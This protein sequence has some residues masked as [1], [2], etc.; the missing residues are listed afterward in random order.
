M[1]NLSWLFLLCGLSCIASGQT[2]PP[3]GDKPEAYCNPV[4]YDTH[5]PTT[6]TCSGLSEEQV[7]DIEKLLR[8]ITT[9]DR[10]NRDVILKRID[11]DAERI[12]T[13]FKNQGIHQQRAISDEEE[14]LMREGQ[15]NGVGEMVII[16]APAG[17][18]E[19]SA[20]AVQLRRIFSQLGFNVPSINYV[21]H[22]PVFPDTDADVV[23]VNNTGTQGG[24]E[25]IWGAF[26]LTTLRFKHVA[27]DRDIH[28]LQPLASGI[29][30]NPKKP[31]NLFVYPNKVR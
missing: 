24:A 15:N 14:Q 6:I 22:L 3:K 20:F 31:I 9:S 10:K 12:I 13:E 26:D 29:D 28:T 27:S 23:M 1:K 2:H 19:A 16:T 5:A 25:F 4:I 7:R 30:W 11:E 21:P 8:G 17:D 18:R